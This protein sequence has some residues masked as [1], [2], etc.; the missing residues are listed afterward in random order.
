[1]ATNRLDS[2]QL[3]RQRSARRSARWWVRFPSEVEALEGTGALS[4]QR[5]HRMTA[6]DLDRVGRLRRLVNAL[7]I[8]RRDVLAYSAT[9]SGA[10]G[11]FRVVVM[12]LVH[13]ADGEPSVYCLDGPRDRATARHRYSDGRLCLYYPK[14]PAS[15]RWTIEDGL[16]GLF[17]LARRHLWAEH[18]L[19]TCDYWPIDE[20]PHGDTPPAAPLIVSPA[21]T[22]LPARNVRCPCGS[23]GKWKRCCGR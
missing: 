11:S 1:M 9:A 5:I 2:R 15:R 23:G 14:D 3:N 12:F 20:A 10:F 16:Q 22:P 6:E 8:D 7:L 18:I 17:D 19:R 4:K 13:P 21:P